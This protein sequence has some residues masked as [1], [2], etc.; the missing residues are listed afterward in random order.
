MVRAEGGRITITGTPA[1]RPLYA[2][3]Q[4]HR[5]VAQAPRQA[6]ELR[7]GYED[8]DGALGYDRVPDT[9]LNHWWM[10]PAGL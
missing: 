1:S 5:D 8:P 2:S 4:R 6:P 7:G 10:D 9:P 3:R